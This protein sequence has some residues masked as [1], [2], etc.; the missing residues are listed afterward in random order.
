MQAD[1]DADRWRRLWPLGRPAKMHAGFGGGSAAFPPV[2]GDAARHDVLPVLAAALG[3]RDDVVE[4]QL[5]RRKSMAA[6]LT[7]VMVTRI[8]ICPREGHVI[9]SA[10]DLDVPQQPD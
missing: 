7:R 4:R 8:N 3:H 9:E 2:A 6:V 5:T 1:G 10:L